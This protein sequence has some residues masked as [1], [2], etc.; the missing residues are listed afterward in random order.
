MANKTKELDAVVVG[1]GFGG[2]YMLH[3]LRRG[4]YSVQGFEAAG[5]VGGVWYW[6][7]YPGARVDSESIY[8]TFT[9][10]EELYK[11]WNWSEKYGAHDEIRAYLNFVAD[12]LDLRRSYQFNTQVVAAHFDESINKWRIQT[13]KGENVLAK[14]FIP[15]TGSLSAANLPNIKGLKDYK[16]EMYHTGKWPHEKVEF[17]GKRVA[18][19]G[20]GSSGIQIITEIAKEAAHLTVFQRT[21]QYSFPS[22][23]HTLDE[24]YIEEIKRNFHEMKRSMFTSDRGRPVYSRGRSALDEPKEIIENVFEEGW[25]EGGRALMEK[26]TDLRKDVNANKLASEFVRRKIKEKI[27][28]PKL[29]EKLIPDYPVGA[30]RLVI[31]SGYFET[32][33]RNNV[34]LVDLRETPILELTEKGIRTTTEE[35]ELDMIVFATGYDAMTGPLLRMDIRGKGGITLNEKWKGGADLKTYLGITL[36]KFPNLFMIG[37]PQT[38]AVHVNVPT[39]NEYIV[40]WVYDCIQYMREHE[41]DTIEPKS[42]SEVEWTNHVNEVASK[43]VY[44]L[45]A[46][47][48]NGGNIEG[49]PRAYLT[50]LGGFQEYQRRCKEGAENGYGKFSI[51]FAGKSY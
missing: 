45:V 44:A 38:P 30:K 20:T 14:T 24:K 36:E 23:N 34:K 16:G 5:D 9:F 27:K 15:A 31:D 50:Y 22:N 47:W 3:V 51:Q 21:P 7:R 1:A 32:Y 41:I 48:Y 33:N 8:Y 43:T 35:H 37:G 39:L 18:V 25:Q 6:N 10:S 42:T 40:D 46:S 29:A 11:E 19:I 49:K 26:Y 13:D 12:R 28:D 4:G 2:L 17:E